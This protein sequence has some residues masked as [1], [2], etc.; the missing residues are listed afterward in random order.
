MITNYH[1]GSG[2]GYGGVYSTVSDL[3]LF[4]RALLIEKTLLSDSMLAQM[5]TFTEVEPETTRAL[6]LGIYDDFHD[7][8]ENERANGHRGRDLQY[9]AD[10]FYFPN[11][12]TTYAFLVN[13]GT[14]G[15]SA[16]ADIFFEFRDAV[17][18]EIC[19]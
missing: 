11:Q 1:T 9:S 19:K 7:R 14:N 16:L 18:D 17:A 2:N 5:M 13:Y 15:S 3:R 10:L 12:H 6:G 4:I 8:P